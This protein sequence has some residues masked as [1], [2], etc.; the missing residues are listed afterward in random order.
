METE[1]VWGLWFLLPSLA[2]QCC[3]SWETTQS[4]P[5][6]SLSLVWGGVLLVVQGQHQPS[7]CGWAAGSTLQSLSSAGQTHERAQEHTQRKHINNSTLIH[8]YGMDRNGVG[9]L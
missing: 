1:V 9:V 2:A 3:R 8:F 5:P 4:P 7:C 6:H